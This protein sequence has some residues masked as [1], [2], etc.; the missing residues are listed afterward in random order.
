M[1]EPLIPN[2]I[3]EPQR[4][5]E[6]NKNEE[7]DDNYNENIKIEEEIKENKEKEPI[8][9]EES[10]ETNEVTFKDLKYKKEKRFVKLAFLIFGIGGLL[11]WNAILSDLDFFNYYLP[12]APIKPDV[13]YPFMN[14]ALNIL[15]QF[16]LICN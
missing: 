7:I 1:T 16:V 14:F 5:E 11:T 6:E 4:I 3:I 8:T 15:F 13:I 2:D 10:K 9:D 12:D